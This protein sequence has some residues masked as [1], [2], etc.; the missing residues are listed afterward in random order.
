MG[1]TNY[2][3]Q[4]D[5]KDQPYL[6]GGWYFTP[7]DLLKFG[8]LYLNQG[9]WKGKALLSASWIKKSM[10]KHTVLENAADKNDYGF[11]FYHK[12]YEVNGLKIA[13]VEGRGSGGQ[14]LFMIPQL[15]LVAVITSGNYRNG[16]V[17]QPE[18]IMEKYIL[19]AVLN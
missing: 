17:F 1:I 5:N 9:K 19:P 13:S 10:A 14:Y 2:R 11:L 12:T 7:R 16:K 6:G 8:Q 18:R 3:I 15:Q 4:T